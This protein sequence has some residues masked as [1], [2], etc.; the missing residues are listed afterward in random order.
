MPRKISR[1]KAKARGLKKYFT[2][3]P[4]C[5]GHV[6][7]RRT[8]NRCCVVCVHGIM[9]RYDESPKGRDKKW[10]Y[11]QSPKG[12][13]AQRR[14]SNSTRRRETLRA[15]QRSHPEYARE[16]RRRERLQHVQAIYDALPSQANWR[17]LQNLIAR[18]TRDGR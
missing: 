12:R 13:E 14:I 10:R 8:D 3:K 4:C 1:A 6:A 9:R 5:R 16:Y 18:R 11:N 2:G 15:Y 17:R 7:E